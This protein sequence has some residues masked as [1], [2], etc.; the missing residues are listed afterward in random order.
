MMVVMV[1]GCKE[2]ML[3]LCEEKD[4]KQRPRRERDEGTEEKNG[5]ECSKVA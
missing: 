2:G 1:E 5:G 4:R 3:V